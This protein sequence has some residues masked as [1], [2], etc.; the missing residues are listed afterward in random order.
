[1]KGRGRGHLLSLCLLQLPLNWPPKGLEC[2][3]FPSLNAGKPVFSK[4]LLQRRCS[5]QPILSSRCHP[6][7]SGEKTKTQQGEMSSPS[8]TASR[9]K[10]QWAG[11]GDPTNAQGRGSW[12]RG[13]STRRALGHKWNSGCFCGQATEAPGSVWRVAQGRR[14]TRTSGIHLEALGLQH[15]SPASRPQPSPHEVTHPRSALRS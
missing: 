5:G 6:H 12:G 14:E 1:M 9:W 11:G 15:S 4:C 10:G 8:S 3:A 2:V 7:F 13:G